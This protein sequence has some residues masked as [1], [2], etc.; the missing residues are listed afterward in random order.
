MGVDIELVT[1]RITRVAE[2]FLNEGE[3]HFFNEDYAFFLEQWGLRGRV[4]Q[5]F[6]TLIWSAKEAFSNGMGGGSW[7]SSGICS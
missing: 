5:E 3:M 1:P 2:K 7:I 6:L 4:E